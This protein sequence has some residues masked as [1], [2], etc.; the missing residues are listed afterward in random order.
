MCKSLLL[1]VVIVGTTR[2]APA[3]D[4]ITARSYYTHDPTNGKRV[5][6]YSPIGPVYVTPR[7]D[8]RKSGY[9]N[10]RSSIQAGGSADHLHIVEEWGNEVRPYGEWRFPFRPHSVPYGAWGPPFGGLQGVPLGLP[11]MPLA[12]PFAPGY[13]PGL[14]PGYRE[15]RG[16]GSDQFWH[17]QPRHRSYDWPRRRA[18]VRQPPWVDGHYPAYRQHQLPRRSDAEFFF[19]M[20][21]TGQQPSTSSSPPQPQP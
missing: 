16:F 2:M 5:T 3:A 7:S 20:Y 13:G 9:R 12:N 4:W 8:Y 19:P 6:Q 15:R 14:A 1:L 11:G 18:P 17:Q 21:G 10:T